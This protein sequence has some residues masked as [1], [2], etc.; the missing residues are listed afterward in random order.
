MP[1]DVVPAVDLAAQLGIATPVASPARRQYDE[2]IMP[3]GILQ[4]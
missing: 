3:S 4:L 2:A 1:K